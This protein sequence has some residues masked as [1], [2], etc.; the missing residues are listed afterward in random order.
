[1]LST[2]ATSVLEVDGLLE[3]V[4]SKISLNPI[5]K[6]FK[7]YKRFI[8]NSKKYLKKCFENDPLKAYFNM[9]YALG[10]VIDNYT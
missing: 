9:Y 10:N 4:A 6:Y 3:S 7:D 8:K 1:M 5:D 2:L